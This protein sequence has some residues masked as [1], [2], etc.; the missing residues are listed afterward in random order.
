MLSPDYLA[1]CTDE[2]L[3]L[4]G[5]LNDAII[6]DIVRRLVNLEFD[7][8]Q[9]AVWQMEKIQQAGY[10]VYED[11]LTEISNITGK[12]EEELRRLFEEAGTESMR[13]DNSV[14][15]RAGLNPLPL[16]QS[17]GM[18]GVLTAG[19][20]KCGGELKNLTLTT[21]NTSQSLFISSCNK[22]YMKTA[23]GAFSYSAAIRDAIEEM[24]RFWCV[25]YVPQRTPGQGGRCSPPR[26]Y[27]RRFP[28][29]RAA[30]D[31]AAG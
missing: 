18:L 30:P 12:S 16:S 26:G 25:D 29:L 10:M 27:D 19:Y 7:V 21:A 6:R 9:S 17:A 31:H 2:I 14:Y 4:Y 1:S 20:K 13:Y 11:V 23:S 5:E 28:D 3:A 15:R 8:S 22:A 24:R